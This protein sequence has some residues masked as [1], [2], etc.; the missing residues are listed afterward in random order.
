MMEDLVL[1]AFGCLGLVSVF[2][3]YFVGSGMT[4]LIELHD[5]QRYHIVLRQGILNKVNAVM[6]YCMFGSMLLSYGGIVG[7]NS[8]SKKLS[9]TMI[10]TGVFMQTTGLMFAKWY[11]FQGA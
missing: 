8:R 5:K 3:N 9:W 10:T 11:I 2:P 4:Y 6:C 1:G 7:L